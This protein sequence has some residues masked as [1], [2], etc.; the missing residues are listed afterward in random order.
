[1]K[2]LLS[3]ACVLLGLICLLTVTLVTGCAKEN[4]FPPIFSVRFIDVGHGDCIYINF[5]DGKNM[6]ID[7]GDYSQ[8]TVDLI[9]KHVKDSGKDCIDRLLLTHVESDHTGSAAEI[10]KVIRIKQ[11]YLPYVL[12]PDNF[13]RF[14]L[15]YNQLISSGTKIHHTKMLDR[16]IQGEDYF[17]VVLSPEPMDFLDSP[18]DDFNKTDTP[19]AEQINATSAVVYLDYMGVRFLFTGDA[20]FGIEKKIIDY[21]EIGYFERAFPDLNIDLRDIDVLK[22]SHHGSQYNTGKDFLE[23]L[24][25]KY[26]VISCGVGTGFPS[27]NLLDRLKKTVPDCKM[28]RTDVDGTILF[29]VDENGDVLI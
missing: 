12:Q 1:M 20:T 19:T 27:T 2:R 28:F 10:A 3:R 13:Y 22:V 25:P 17:M 24:M 7:T 26:A 21:Y 23:L 16:I 18:Y 29:R 9:E 4:E 15:A 5:P 6:L 11:A 8:E 14:S